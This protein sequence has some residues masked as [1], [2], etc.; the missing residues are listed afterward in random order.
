MEDKWIDKEQ[1]F[2]EMDDGRVFCWD[3]KALSILLVEGIIFANSRDYIEWD[4]W[5]PDEE[6]PGKFKHLDTYK[7]Q[8][9]TIVLFV[10]CNDLFWW[11]SADAESFTIGEVEELYKMWRADKKWG[12]SKW[13]C[14]KRGMQPQLP[15]KEDMIKE[16][17]WEDWMNNLTDPGPS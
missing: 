1:V 9:E 17:V 10:N 13:C 16:G 2:Y 8:D 11:G 6:N 7:V 5:V 4:K 3:E 14:K 12:V 15:I